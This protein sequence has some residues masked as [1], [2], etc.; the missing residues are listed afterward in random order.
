MELYCER[1]GSKGPT[2]VLLHGLAGNGAVWR[3][4]IEELRGLWPGNILVPDLRGHGRSPHGSHYSFGQYAADVAD[5]LDPG[6]RIW[7]VAH[8]MGAVV[9]LTL[10]SGWYG[11][12]LGAV[13]G[14]GMKVNWTEAESEKALS[15]SQ[16]PVR[17]FDT[18]HEAAERYL[19][20]SGLA[21]LAA[22]D[23]A[24]VDAGLR[25]ENGRW[26]FAADAKTFA[27]RKPAYE[28]IVRLAKGRVI[29]ACGSNDAMVTVAEL[30]R[31]DPAAIELQGL[32]HNLHLEAPQ[33][34]A[35]QIEQSILPLL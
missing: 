33:A 21:G 22:E 3:P 32:G 6:E 4:L 29:L 34:L 26:R 31:F 28:E 13:L 2:L 18:R 9:A 10:A 16:V 19:R 7:S 35:R 5:L 12:S 27:A 14:F 1:I 30:R 11:V 25:Q 17:W 20:L 15:L 24:A 23:C 8:S